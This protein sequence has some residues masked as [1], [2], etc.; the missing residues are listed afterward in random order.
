MT[1]VLTYLASWL[2]PINVLVWVAGADAHDIALR[3][4]L[5]PQVW[6][7]TRRDC[8]D[9]HDLPQRLCATCGL[10]PKQHLGSPCICQDFKWLCPR[11]KM[12][13]R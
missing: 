11:C 13:V 8:R 4:W 2:V 3:S 5:P 7:L 1:K 12:R 6:R 9:G 10:N